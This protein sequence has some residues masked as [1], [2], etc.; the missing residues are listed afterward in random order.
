MTD[1]QSQALVVTTAGE[2]VNPAPPNQGAFQINPS[3]AAPIGTPSFEACL[4]ETMYAIQLMTC[5]PFAI[6]DMLNYMR[7][8]WPEKWPQAVDGFSQ[9]YS[10]TTIRNYMSVARRVPQHLRNSALGWNYHDAVAALE[11]QAQAK[12]LAEAVSEGWG[13]DEV[14]SQARLVRG[15]HVLRRFTFR[16][17]GIEPVFQ[18]GGIKDWVCK[19][20]IVLTENGD[21]PTGEAEV[22]IVE[23][24]P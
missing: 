9:R 24:L 21:I 2:P 12:L 14:R 1:K 16:C 23:A 22:E 6:G 5:L 4:S 19:D 15:L 20:V 10:A 7:D 13:Y 11:P 3:G 8:R 17:R 18:P